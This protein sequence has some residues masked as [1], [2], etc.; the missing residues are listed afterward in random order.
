MIT[1]LMKQML[2]HQT[3]EQDNLGDFPPPVDS[4]YLFDSSKDHLVRSSC[5]FRCLQ[6]D[7]YHHGS[8]VKMIGGKAATI[9]SQEPIRKQANKRPGDGVDAM[10]GN[11][12][13]VY[14]TRPEHEFSFKRSLRSVSITSSGSLSAMFVY[15]KVV[16]DLTAFRVSTVETLAVDG[17][18]LLPL[19]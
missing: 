12:T 1:H 19:I 13:R 14:T 11:N 10:C 6:G 8:V 16:F 2:Q 9:Y 18:N 7:F 15:S 5:G 17:P 4:Q 3:E